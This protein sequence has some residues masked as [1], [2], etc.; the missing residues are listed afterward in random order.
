MILASLRAGSAVF[1]ITVAMLTL[2]QAA[3]FALWTT[4]WRMAV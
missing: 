3:T 2:L 1:A 4:G